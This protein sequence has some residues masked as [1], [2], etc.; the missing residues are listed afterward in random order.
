M[1]SEKVLKGLSFWEFGVFV[2][3]SVLW[4]G[5]FILLTVRKIHVYDT[6]WH[7]ASGKYIVEHLTIPSYDPFS[8]TATNTPWT[9]VA[10]LFQIFLYGW[11][12]ILGYNG[13]VAFKVFALAAAFA[14]IWLTMRRLTSDR[15]LCMAIM[16]CILIAA[17]FR[18]I[19]RPDF[20]AYLI[21]CLFMWFLVRFLEQPSWKGIVPF[22]IL[23]L[24]WANMHASFIIGVFICSI[25]LCVELLQSRKDQVAD[26]IKRKSFRL[27]AALLAAVLLC[28]LI[29]PYGIDLYFQVFP[30]N[31]EE[32]KE[33]MRHIMEWYSVSPAFFFSF[34]W[35]ERLFFKL[36]LWMT[37]LF[38]LFRLKEK[39]DASIVGWI[40]YI[41]GM[42]YMVI[43][44][45]RLASFAI[46]SLAPVCVLLAEGKL[47]L[48]KGYSLRVPISKTVIGTASV[49][50][51]F[52]AILF[53]THQLWSRTLPYRDT[54]F[55]VYWLNYPK[56]LVDVV[57]EENIPGPLFNNYG[58]GGFLIWH[59]YPDHKVFIDGRVNNL[60]DAD[61]FWLY[62]QIEAGR[63][64]AIE[65][66]LEKYP[67]K[68]V[69]T[70]SAAL[71]KMLEDNFNFSFVGFDNVGFLL[72]SQSVKPENL[73]SFENYKP[74]QSPMQ[75]VDEA[76][77]K[78][79]D[80]LKALEKEMLY[81]TQR[82]PSIK[83]FEHAGILYAKGFEDYNKASVF[84]SKALELAGGRNPKLLYNVASCSFEMGQYEEAISMVKKSLVY[85]NSNRE[86][87][88]LLAKAFYHK[89]M[90]EEAL[91]AIKRYIII[92][93]DAATMEGYQYLGM[94][95]NEMYD[96][97]GAIKAFKRAL[98]IPGSDEERKIVFYNLGRCYEA[99]G[100]FRNA[101]VFLDKA[102]EID[103]HF[104]KALAAKR[105]LGKDYYNR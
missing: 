57:K 63:K 40:L 51:I 62:R 60:Y 5:G 53:M 22:V 72:V 8:Y 80:F 14:V 71:S 96:L 86:G 85:D 10:W 4:I 56:A 18:F 90:Y 83:S 6:W 47:L 79:G 20:L 68:T 2:V 100:D 38:A 59:M 93:D 26:I 31:G 74:Y 77:K 103:P 44:A 48:R 42:V 78:G 12:R 16:W 9:D 19:C 46:F 69:I 29:T 94:I 104:D 70:Q 64:E 39:G 61:L 25:P 82:F 15:L 43:A 81:A 97:E 17:S 101:Q 75:Q 28:T 3:S 76:K 36:A 7:L 33:A 54:G 49:S 41:A 23:M 37:T 27:K 84:Y 98:A 1:K 30:K 92:A 52:L 34:T 87:W 105:E 99:L 32:A 50:I 66:T 102:L 58:W 88:L 73:Q 24:F 13:V 95:R 91:D 45:Y 35:D 21:L 55:G 65:F 67:F 89:E 11:Y